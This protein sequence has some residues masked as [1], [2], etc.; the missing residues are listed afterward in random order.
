VNPLLGHHDSRDNLLH[1]TCL[2]TLIL[3]S[4][5]VYPP[6]SFKVIHSFSIP[7]DQS[8]SLL[9]WH[10]CSWGMAPNVLQNYSLNI[11]HLDLLLYQMGYVSCKYQISSC[12]SASYMLCGH[13]VFSMSACSSW[14]IFSALT[15]WD[16]LAIFQHSTQNFSLLWRLP[17]HSP[18]K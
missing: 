5:W 1:M 8:P 2:H 13:Y 15:T 16:N 4:S 11:T 17:N 6:T 7:F 10:T 9:K 3:R 14:Q 18:S 12:L